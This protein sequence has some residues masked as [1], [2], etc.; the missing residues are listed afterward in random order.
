MDKF[1]AVWEKIDAV[2][3]QLLRHVCAVILGAPAP[4]TK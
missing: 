3:F 2:L 1:R 4:A